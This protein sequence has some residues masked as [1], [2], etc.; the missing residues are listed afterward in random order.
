MKVGVVFGC[1]FALRV[2]ANGA[3]TEGDTAFEADGQMLVR[4]Q[5]L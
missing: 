1:V 5:R 4:L 3:E 2:V